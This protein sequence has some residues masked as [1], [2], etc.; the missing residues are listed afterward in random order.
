LHLNVDGARL[1]ALERHRRDPLD[2]A[3]CPPLSAKPIARRIRQARTI[4][5]QRT[6]A[7]R[8]AT[9]IDHCPSSCGCSVRSASLELLMSD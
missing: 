8:L 9:T 5:E 7:P 1:D 4:Q 2:H 3:G 6:Y